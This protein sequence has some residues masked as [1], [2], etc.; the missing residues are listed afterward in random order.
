MRKFVVRWG[1]GGALPRGG[2]LP[3]V[4]LTLTTSQT[5]RRRQKV[6][7]AKAK[8][9]ALKIHFLAEM[10]YHVLELTSNG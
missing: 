10:S 6:T 9:S 4:T 3:H 5:L 7:T 8:I 1:G 2:A